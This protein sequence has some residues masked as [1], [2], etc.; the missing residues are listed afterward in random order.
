MLLIV[1]LAAANCGAL[2]KSKHRGRHRISTTS[3]ARGTRVTCHVVTAC[4][5]TNCQQSCCNISQIRTLDVS[6]KVPLVLIINSCNSPAEKYLLCSLF[7]CSVRG[8]GL[9][10]ILGA[11]ISMRKNSGDMNGSH[12]LH[13][14]S[15]RSGRWNESQLNLGRWES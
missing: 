2:I 15:P 7:L 14:S 1:R 11:I 9:M 3:P 6:I 4:Y 10:T 5:V 8:G 13:F 12:L